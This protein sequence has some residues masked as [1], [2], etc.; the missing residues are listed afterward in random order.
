M[1]KNPASTE[2]PPSPPWY[3]GLAIGSVFLMAAILLTYTLAGWSWQQWLG[4]WVNY[5]VTIGLVVVVS[6]MMRLWR[7]NNDPRGT[8]SMADALGRSPAAG[9]AEPAPATEQSHDR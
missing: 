3:G 4:P 7:P 9:H 2:R 6:L 5:G 1:T 8:T